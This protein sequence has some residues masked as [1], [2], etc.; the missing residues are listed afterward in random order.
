MKLVK[1][2]ALI[3]ITTILLVSFQNCS[4]KQNAGLLGSKSNGLTEAQTAVIN[5][6]F[7][8]D[9]AVDTISYNSCSGSDLNGQGI[10]GLKLGVNEGFIDSTGVGA[11]KAGVK[12][13]SDFL[14][15]VGQT[16]T[17]NYPS[18]VVTPAQIQYV[19]S[20]SPY[21]TDSFIQYAVRRKSDLTVLLD[22]IDQTKAV[23]AAGRDGIIDEPSLRTDVMMSELAKNVV[24]GP[25]GV[26]LAEGS[27]VY[28]LGPKS[29]PKPVEASFGYTNAVDGTYPAVANADDG[30]G[31]GEQYADVVR[32]K[33]NSGGADKV[34][35]AI[36]FG[37]PYDPKVAA[38]PDH[39]LNTPKRPDDKLRAKAFG[40]GYELKFQSN[41]AKAGWKENRLANVTEVNLEQNASIGLMSWSCSSFVIMKQTHW[42]NPK[43][44]EA[45]CAPL[46]ATDLQNPT[47]AG[48]IKLIRRHYSE[49]E[50][51]IGVFYKKN[52]TYLPSTRPVYPPST[53]SPPIP[54][55]CLVP[56]VKECYLVT[57]GLTADKA[58]IGVQYDDTQE[59]Y[60]SRY[61]FM[62]V[63][64]SGGISGDAIR[65]LGR[66][67]QY[68]SICK[69][70]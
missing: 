34:I 67:A 11:L 5:A 42:N 61:P 48:P 53:G 26:V 15:Y 63:T 23:F 22:Q 39:G 7:A 70:N 66:C 55:L 36:T 57:T 54:L 40:R 51:N 13:R 47:L 41:S 2:F 64:Y 4:I 3:F 31:A 8:F 1:S 37:N 58:D 43:P 27:Y 6:P 65:K 19:I 17:P 24:Y 21:N 30:T 69:R 18:N 9:V 52:T 38:T 56:K 35:L 62:G 28:N 20:N 10:H 60:L 68:A 33:F 49:P 25:G 59:C 29:E 16:I 46:N 32:K 44:D 12:L 45:S 50:W 14:T